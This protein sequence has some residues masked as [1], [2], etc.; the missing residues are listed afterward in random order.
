[1]A[2]EL[3]PLVGQWYWHHDK[4]Q[5]FMVVAVEED[6]VEI[7]HYDGD[8]EEMDLD[9][10]SEMDIEPGE[11]PEDW[12]GPTDDVDAGEP[13]FTDAS[14]EEGFRGSEGEDYR[15][16]PEGWANEP[17]ARESADEDEG[18]PEQG[19]GGEGEEEGSSDTADKNE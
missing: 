2:N 8:L 19:E 13:G 3:E 5:S 16:P 14:L 10:W 1:M 15:R 9:A 7:Q 17:E 12:S 4:G 11:A 6:L 18:V